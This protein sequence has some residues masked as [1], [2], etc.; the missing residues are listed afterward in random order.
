MTSKLPVIV[1]IDANNVAEEIIFYH[2][3]GNE[4]ICKF[5]DVNPP[6]KK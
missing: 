2:P 1:V 4:K 5:S 6:G 3:S